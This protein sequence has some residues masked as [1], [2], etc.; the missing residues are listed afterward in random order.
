MQ[1]RLVTLADQCTQLNE[2]NRA[3]QQFQQTELEHFRN[4]LQDCLPIENEF[5]FDE[6]AQFILDY[7]NEMNS[8][9][10][11]L[12]QKLNL[13]EMINYDLQTSESLLELMRKLSCSP[14]VFKN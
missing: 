8:E 7:F 9:R 14:L 12:V 5:S 2:A 13:T 6:I 10:N 4:K 11:T 1:E 3:W